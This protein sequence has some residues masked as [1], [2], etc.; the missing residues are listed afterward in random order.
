[1]SDLLSLIDSSGD[2]I[3]EIVD[4]AIHIKNNQQK[5]HNA[6]NRKTLAMLFQKSSTR[7]RVSFEC[8]MV[9]LGGH[10]IYLDWEKTNFILGDI[11]DEVRYLSSNVD[12]IMARV[13]RNDALE[14]MHEASSVPVINGCCNKFHPCQILCD[15][16]TIK[17]VFGRFEGV[18]LVFLGIH[19]NVANSLLIGCTKVGMKV[20]LIT[21]ERN[22][23]AYDVNL[24]KEAESTG[25]LD[26][27]YGDEIDQKVVDEHLSNADIIYTDTWIDMEFFLDPN[28]KDEKE[29]RIKTFAPYQINKEMISKSRAKIMHDMPIHIGY[30]ITRDAVDHKNSIIFH[31]AENRLHGQKAVLLK[32]MN[33]S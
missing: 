9:Q 20:T 13:L 2:D 17:E 31:Q 12:I 23:D 4:M 6:L 27:L 14:I 18:H 5:Y 21:P 24:I 19:N 7:T 11:K 3:Q 25:L 16:T 30:E 8:A 28:F 26:I 10:A 32:L 33:K 29:R 1:M 22:R 15:L